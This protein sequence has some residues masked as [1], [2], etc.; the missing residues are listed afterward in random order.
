MKAVFTVI[1][2]CCIIANFS[3]SCVHRNWIGSDWKE[4][5]REQKQIERILYLKRPTRHQFP[6]MTIVNGQS[7]FMNPKSSG[8]FIGGFYASQTEITNE[9]FCFF[10]NAIKDTSRLFSNADTLQRLF[11]IGLPNKAITRNEQGQYTI[12]RSLSQHPVTYVNYAGALLY[13]NWLSAYYGS[14]FNLNSG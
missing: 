13:C 10:L 1:T 4:Y 12:D 8:I 9:Q 7:Y 3:T 6:K 5:S 2:I 14:F 11:G